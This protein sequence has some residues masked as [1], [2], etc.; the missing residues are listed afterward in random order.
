MLGAGL[1]CQNDMPNAYKGAADC[2]SAPSESVL[3][4]ASNASV[5]TVGASFGCGSSLAV[6]VADT[7]DEADVV[8]VAGSA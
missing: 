4:A 8:A 2:A 7:R 5:A 1:H 6:A 3:V